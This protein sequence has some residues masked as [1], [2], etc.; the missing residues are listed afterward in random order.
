ME[1]FLILLVVGY[2]LLPLIL[3]AM[4]ARLRRDLDALTARLRRVE[5][6]PAAQPTATGAA[7]APDAL[8]AGAEAP[9]QPPQQQPAPPFQ[10]PASGPFAPGRRAPPPAPEVA[11][12][13][14]PA[15]A[16]EQA[17]EAAAPAGPPVPPPLP[18][19]APPPGPGLEQQIGTRWLVWLGGL[20]LALSGLFLV[21]YSVESG[22]LGPG[23]RLLIGLLLG[24]GL[25][26][27]GEALR[28]RPDIVPTRMSWSHIP[29][30]VTAAGLLTLFASLY[31][32]YALYGLIP[33]FVAFAGLAAVALLAQGLAILHGPLL[34]L[35]GLVGAFAA[36]ALV[37]SDAPS[38]IGLLIYLQLVLAASLGVIRYTGVVWLAWA[39][40]AFAGAWPVLWMAGER[41]SPGDGAL[42]GL[43]A[44]ALLGQFLTLPRPA[45]ARSAG[46]P[47]NPRG[48]SPA[49]RL[50][51]AAGLVG[52]ALLGF[53]AEY[54]GHAVGSVA[55]ALVFIATAP[56]LGRLQQ[57]LQHFAAFALLLA[58]WLAATW[59]LPAFIPERPPLVTIAGVPLGRMPGPLVPAELGGYLGLVLG[60]MAGYGLLAGRLLVGA[61]HPGLWAALSAGGP[62][63]LAI[64]AYGRAA[65]L[66][67][68]LQ[69]ALGFLALAGAAVLGAGWAR[70]LMPPERH[71]AAVAAYSAAA[72]AAV[73]L[74]LA[75]LLREAWLS[76]ALSLQLPAL[77]LIHRRLPVAG[78]RWLALAVAGLVLVRLLGNPF[79]L[80][81]DHG[82][83]WAL[84]AYGVPALS[85]HLAWR[86]F[87]RDG[88]GLLETVLE[89]GR[90]AFAVLLAMSQIRYLVQGRYDAPALAL[91]EL[92]GY[93]AVWI[94][95]ATLLLRA[96]AATPR[97][98]LV[99][100]WRILAG[101]AAAA[102]VFGHLL[103][104]NPFVTEAD[105][106][107]DAPPLLNPLFPAYAL[108]AGLLLGFAWQ[109]AR[110]GLGRLA[111]GAGLAAVG[112]GFVYVTAE[113]RLAFGGFTYEGVPHESLQAESYAYSAV[114][115]LY[116]LALF[117]LGLWR[118]FV[119]LRQLGLGLVL[120]T[121]VKV[122]LIDMAELDGLLRVAS[123]LGLGLSLIALGWVYQ[124]FVALA[125]QGA[126][127]A[128]GGAAGPSGPAS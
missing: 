72:V 112:L 95:T 38:L 66:D 21:R 98:V 81:Y 51:L 27:A 3:L 43:Y 14:P 22:L 23:A 40:L 19:P 9:P 48:L 39:A 54:D 126:P 82:W 94:A 60:L 109:A 101:L 122:F 47:L 31:G 110:Q 127:A 30:A 65:E 108:P 6:G 118:R 89:S 53:V 61:A 79:L 106:P 12:V 97:P 69:W 99:W 45:A 33:P 128:P 90:L 77:A 88:D 104:L 46:A 29:A 120:L 56:V 41:P 116:A 37:A 121:V 15:L 114:W 58:L 86:L 78:L 111:A 18:P 20:A 44:L 11:A 59:P 52:T 85:F 93:T 7:A 76:V 105:W 49:D 84:Y 74:G 125:P 17:G 83:N 71:D 1:V 67:V 63:L 4:V 35:L 70:R 25:T 68:D 91:V 36:P 113:V 103:A 57:G 2:A 87:R 13:P 80:D 10:V 117:G 42:L 55:T 62:V 107:L 50:A 24:A 34:G 75:A 96:S 26:V 64:L 32:G 16:V 73:S 102:L 123:F 5:Q 100:G 119:R 124:R 8:S 92:A 28:R 115:L